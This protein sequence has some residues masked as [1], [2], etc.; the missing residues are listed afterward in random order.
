MIGV[1]KITNPSQDVYIGSSKD[2]QKRLSKHRRN[3]TNKLLKA[4]IDK[5]GWEAHKKEIVLQCN[6]SELNKEEKACILMHCKTHNVL[7]YYNVINKE[8]KHTGYITNRIIVDLFKNSGLSELEFSTKHLISQL[9]LR[10]W[11]VGNT[12]PK[13]TFIAI[14]SKNEPFLIKWEF[15][16]NKIIKWTHKEK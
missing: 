7:N 3:S 13:K 4:S 1:Y 16:L 11:L 14:I 8:N 6:E 12:K 15:E 9:T 5:Y 2:I 10:N